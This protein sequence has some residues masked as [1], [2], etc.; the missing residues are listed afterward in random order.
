MLRLRVSRKTRPVR[1]IARVLRSSACQPK[2]VSPVKRF[3]YQQT[4]QTAKAAGD[5]T[6]SARALNVRAEAKRHRNPLRRFA[7]ARTTPRRA[8]RPTTARVM[9]AREG[10]RQ[11]GLCRRA[12]RRAKSQA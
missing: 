3:T 4:N 10:A 9:V 1:A 11:E 12:E 2:G 5:A 6:E 8:T 7:E